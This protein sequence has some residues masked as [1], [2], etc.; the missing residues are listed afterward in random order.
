MR[1]V[2]ALLALFFLACIPAFSQAPPPIDRLPKDVV[3]FFAWNGLGSVQKARAT[4]GLLRLWDDPE[5][6]AIR[7]LLMDRT[8]RDAK[9]EQRTSKEEMDL[10][11][12]AAS[13]PFIFGIANL[14]SEKK[15][16]PIP[17]KTIPT[18]LFMIYDQT[19]KA[20]VVDKIS[21]L[22]AKNRKI[23]PVT[24][25]SSFSGVTITKE[26]TEK[27]TS[28]SAKSGNYFLY[29]DTPE[30]METLIR[31]LTAVA[32]ASVV[33]T[34]AYQAAAAQ[35]APDSFCEFFF[36]MP[37]LSKMEVPV[38]QGMNITAMV[39]GLHLER[40]Q[41]VTASASLAGNGMRLRFA[42]VGDT[43]PGS[44]FDLVGNSNG[45]FRT[46]ALAQPG[47][48]YNATRFD[49][50][51][52]YKTLRAAIQGGLSTEQATQLEMFEGMAGMQLGMNVTEALQ[53]MT[54]EF[55]SI[56]LQS[57]NT[58]STNGGNPIDLQNNLYALA[59]QHPDDVLKVIQLTAGKNLTS[60]T[61]EGDASILAIAVPYVDEKTGAQRK[62]FH[63]IG[64]TPNMV[65]V[66][67][68]RTV[69]KEA[70]A[71]AH[72]Q[73]GPAGSSLIA[74]PSFQQVRNRLPNQLSGLSYS[75]LNHFPWQ[76]LVD[77]MIQEAN[78]KEADKLSAQEE[79]TLRKLPGVISRYLR[80][81]FGG[82]WKD[83]AGVYL[84]SYIE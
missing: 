39:K 67:P 29:T 61:R 79:Q 23:A 22:D 59:I 69:L 37:D 35:R 73:Q 5:F 2:F 44:V 12:D 80:V 58:A 17:G 51:A 10:I 16:T 47:S 20:E 63:Y 19:G 1:R 66:A 48:S 82:A 74:D 7:Q 49:L 68:R 4:N 50:N 28:Y 30:V 31:Q 77:G 54:G 38:T 26:E 6:A 83:R 76:L 33:S 72:A 14:P 15:P 57:E 75:D 64:I 18:G 81:S 43:S 62:R 71:R 46:L 84:D 53:L 3:F 27:N 24:T 78:K 40:L 45:E 55:A 21:Q 9:P 70:I 60:E 42:A 11:L 32:P 56:S 52:F 65:I 36:K 25:T 13:N 8:Q 41:A 34:A